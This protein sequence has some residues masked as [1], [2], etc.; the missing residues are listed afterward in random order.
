MVEAFD[1]KVCFHLFSGEKADIKRIVHQ[2]VDKYD[3]ISQFARVAVMK[4]LREE[5]EKVKE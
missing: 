1:E 3:N 5:R 4:L 2:N